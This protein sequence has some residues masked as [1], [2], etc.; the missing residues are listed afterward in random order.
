MSKQS[1]LDEIINSAYEGEVSWTHDQLDG[2]NMV[3]DVIKGI[4]DEKAKTKQAILDWHNKQVEEVLDRLEGSIDDGKLS[5]RMN[6]IK[7][8][9][10]AERNKLKEKK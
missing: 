6:V 7:A 8:A 1:E 4:E 5:H 10:E 9:I 3:D 2:T